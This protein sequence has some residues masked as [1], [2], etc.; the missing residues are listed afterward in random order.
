MKHKIAIIFTVLCAL[1]YAQSALAGPM[2]C[3]DEKTKC[4]AACKLVISRTGLSPCV[5]NCNARQIMCVRTSCWDD[6][7]NRY[8]GLARQ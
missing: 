8:C 2:R 1:A 5:T 3:S 7:T 4:L 6:G